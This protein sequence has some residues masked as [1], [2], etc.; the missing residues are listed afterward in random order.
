MEVFV[1]GQDLVNSRWGEEQSL[2]D[3]HVGFQSGT[4]GAADAGG[5][6]NVSYGQAPMISQSSSLVA[7]S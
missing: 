2:L 1:V 3:G 5:S 7:A 4:P 6:D